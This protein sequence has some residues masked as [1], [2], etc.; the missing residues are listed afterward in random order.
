LMYQRYIWMRSITDW[1]CRFWRRLI[2]LLHN[3]CTSRSLCF[4]VW[5]KWTCAGPKY[6][7]ENTWG[8]KG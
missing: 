4:Y 2:T 3:S 1:S 5:N 7:G 8:L 6:S